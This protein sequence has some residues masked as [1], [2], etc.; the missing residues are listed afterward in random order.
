MG[1][2]TEPR[3][4]TIG[5]MGYNQKLTNSLF[6]WF[7]ENNKEE[8]VQCRFGGWNPTVVFKDGTQIIP[9]FSPSQQRGLKLDQL[10]LCDDDRWNIYSNRFSDIEIIRLCN[11]SITNVPEEFQILEYL[12]DKRIDE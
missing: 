12:Y 1:F 9:I 8:L 5:F 2:E 3:S 4:L 10:I 6:K 7:C 11:M